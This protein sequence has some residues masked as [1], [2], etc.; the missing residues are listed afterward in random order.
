MANLTNNSGQTFKTRITE[1][2]DPTVTIDAS[3]FTEA[4]YRIFA[5]DCTTVLVEATLTGGDIAVVSDTDESGATINVFETTLTK[6]AMDDTIVPA[7]QYTHQF[8]VTNSDS[9]ELPP[10]F[11][12]TVTIVRACD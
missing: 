6:A 2:Q 11:Q 1:A 4:K 9:L 12:N 8:K 3:S 7:G 10:V 5:S